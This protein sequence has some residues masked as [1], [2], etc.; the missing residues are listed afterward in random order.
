[1]RFLRT[2]DTV[3]LGENA[4]LRTPFNTKEL[5]NIVNLYFMIKIADLY[6]YEVI[7]ILN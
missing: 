1:M 5:E 3:N 6:L 4:T 7:L 2:N